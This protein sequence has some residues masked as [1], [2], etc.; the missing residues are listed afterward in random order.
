MDGRRASPS[1]T[2]TALAL[3]RS[4]MH[5]ACATMQAPVAVRTV[6][7]QVGEGGELRR[8]HILLNVDLSSPNE[9]TK[10]GPSQYGGDLQ[11]GCMRPISSGMGQ[12]LYVPLPII[13]CLGI[14]DGE[15][16]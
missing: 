13:I 8:P 12:E 2:Y 15:V 3:A 5:S 6:G 14:R 9:R 16:L 4:L 10:F 1:E 11:N 7:I